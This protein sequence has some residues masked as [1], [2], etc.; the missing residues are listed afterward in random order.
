MRNEE[1]LYV[2]DARRRK[3]DPLYC[4]QIRTH[5]EHGGIVAWEISGPEPGEFEEGRTELELEDW[6]GGDTFAVAEM[7]QVREYIADMVSY[8][9][10]EVEARSP[11]DFEQA[12][13][14]ERHLGLAWEAWDR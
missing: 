4:L 12:A 1:T 14:I 13:E 10:Q 9:K 2:Q 3:F 11:R 8:L 7:A 6:C 5:E